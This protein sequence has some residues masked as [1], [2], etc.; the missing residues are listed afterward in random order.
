VTAPDDHAARATQASCAQAGG[1]KKII[2]AAAA[3][4]VFKSLL[5]SQ[6]GFVET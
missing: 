5:Q 6:I 2:A 3:I 1:A 4:S